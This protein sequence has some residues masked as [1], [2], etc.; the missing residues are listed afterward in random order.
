MTKKG[1][2]KKQITIIEKVSKEELLKSGDDTKKAEED[3]FKVREDD[4]SSSSI[5]N[6]CPSIT[7]FVPLF[8]FL[9]SLEWYVV[10]IV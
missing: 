8:A 3:I 6:D 9:K 4:E 5:W 2:R 1:K 10:T 7:T